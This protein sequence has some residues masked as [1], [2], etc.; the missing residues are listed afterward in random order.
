[1][2]FFFFT[3][4]LIEEDKA[5]KFLPICVF[6]MEEPSDY[7][8]HNRLREFA[9]RNQEVLD[10]PGRA[11][12][13]QASAAVDP[14]IPGGAA[15]PSEM[16]DFTYLITR[17]CHIKPFGAAA[18]ENVMAILTSMTTYLKTRSASS[19]R[20]GSGIMQ[21]NDPDPGWLYWDQQYERCLW[22]IDEWQRT[23]NMRFDHEKWD[24]AHKRG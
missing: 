17:I 24:L 21:G 1:M 3:Y 8:L 19:Q 7:L 11:Q 6:D 15:I 22:L 20:E 14:G 18:S 9:H 16:T 23:V 13:I 2:L 12:T 10:C 4:E 5:M